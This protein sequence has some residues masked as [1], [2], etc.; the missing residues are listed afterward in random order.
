M[1]DEE[2]K[3][4]IWKQEENTG[5]LLLKVDIDL[6]AG[7][8]A[9]MC[10]YSWRLKNGKEK[11]GL[12]VRAS[13]SNW[14]EC[15]QYADNLV[16]FLNTLVAHLDGSFKL[17]C[18]SYWYLY[19]RSYH[20]FSMNVIQMVFNAAIVLLSFGIILILTFAYY[21]YLLTEVGNTVWGLLM[22]SSGQSKM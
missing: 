5:P 1:I 20:S 17:N 10:R 18:Y 19:D 7:W 14:S 2:I 15:Y 16:T 3:K 8:E 21:L 6:S 13:M 9:E 4:V 12:A 22:G 11:D